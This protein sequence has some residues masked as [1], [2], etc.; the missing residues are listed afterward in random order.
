MTDAGTLVGRTVSDGLI[1]LI[2]GLVVRYPAP[3]VHMSIVSTS[4]TLNRE[5]VM[6]NTLCLEVLFSKYCSFVF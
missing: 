1:S 3:L 5:Y 2:V 4:K 6:A